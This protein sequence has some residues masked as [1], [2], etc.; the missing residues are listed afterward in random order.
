MDFQI[1]IAAESNQIA[2]G[3]FIS[4]HVSHQFQFSVFET[5][6]ADK[7]LNFLPKMIEITD[8]RFIQEKALY[9]KYTS[10]ME[11]LEDIHQIEHTVTILREVYS[12]DQLQLAQKLKKYCHKMVYNIEMCSG[13]FINAMD[14]E[15]NPNDWFTRMLTT[16]SIGMGPSW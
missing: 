15:K 13:C 11:F 12:T 8:L 14:R 4:F 10:P 9:K 2:V 3:F 1:E 5:I 16:S 7:Q 6:E